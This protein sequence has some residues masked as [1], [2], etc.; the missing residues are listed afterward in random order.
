[1][2]HMTS[3]DLYDFHLWVV[4]SYASAIILLHIQ[5]WKLHMC[6]VEADS[7]EPFIQLEFP[8][9]PKPSPNSHVPG[10]MKLLSRLL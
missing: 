6:G 9:G 4:N 2:T 10:L 8:V 1:M 5:I 7:R 3:Y